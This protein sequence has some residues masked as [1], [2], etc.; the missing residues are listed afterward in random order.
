MSKEGKGKTEYAVYK[1]REPGVYDS[2]SA[3]KEQVNGYP[4]NCFEKV[5]SSA[6][7]NYVVYEGSK[8]GV[9]G[10]WQQTHQQVSGYSGNSYERCDNRAVAQD[11]YSAY[12]GK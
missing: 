1:G 5:G 3:A 11:K 10:S 2:W 6:S 8:P 9:Y 12:R 7:K 4:G